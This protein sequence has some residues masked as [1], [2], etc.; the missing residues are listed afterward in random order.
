MSP[1]QAVALVM[2]FLRA[3]LYAAGPVLLVALAAGVLVGI[4][5]TATQINESSIS[6]LVKVGAVVFVILTLG[7]MLATYV[8]DY[9][10]TSLQSIGDVV[11]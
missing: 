6:F 10:R 1:D 5:Q 4:L 9:T 11:R 3:A 8:T 7:P 2:A